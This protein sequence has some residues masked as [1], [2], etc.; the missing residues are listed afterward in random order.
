MVTLT[1]NVPQSFA[2]WLLQAAED[3]NTDLGGVVFELAA[4]A[5]DSE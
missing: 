4:Y 2:A 5:E 3:L 1:I